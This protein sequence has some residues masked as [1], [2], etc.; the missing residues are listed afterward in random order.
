MLESYLSLTNK[1]KAGK[2]KYDWMLIGISE[3]EVEPKVRELLPFTEKDIHFLWKS[4]YV[5][6]QIETPPSQPMQQSILNTLDEIFQA[7]LASKNNKTAVN[8][9]NDVCDISWAT[10]DATLSVLL[11]NEKSVT[12]GKPPLCAEVSI[13][14]TLASVVTSDNLLEK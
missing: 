2:N 5:L 7:H 14:P 13:N 6:M 10:P 1:R 12:E 4:P 11:L 8:L 3:G 9:L